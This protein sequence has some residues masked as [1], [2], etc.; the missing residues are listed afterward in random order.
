MGID[1]F[2]VKLFVGLF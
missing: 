1:Y 2:L